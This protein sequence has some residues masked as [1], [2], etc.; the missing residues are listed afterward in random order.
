[1]LGLTLRKKP[2]D[3][4]LRGTA[5]ARLSNLEVAARFIDIS[6]SGKA[7]EQL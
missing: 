4:R 2:Q 5:N 1:M 3:R 7:G 6:R